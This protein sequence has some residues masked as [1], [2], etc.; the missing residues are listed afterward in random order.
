MIN[1]NVYLGFTVKAKIAFK[2]LS[3]KILKTFRGKVEGGQN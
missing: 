2:D 1:M 3:L